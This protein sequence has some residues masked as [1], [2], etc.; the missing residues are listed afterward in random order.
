MATL[1][2]V[3]PPNELVFNGPFTEVTEKAIHLFN[4]S[5]KDV[6]FKVKTTAPRKYCV[7]PNNGI[8]EV[9]KQQDVL[10]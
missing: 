7:R 3:D 5:E 6:C 8:I 1:L 4:V 2:R 9:G 10:G